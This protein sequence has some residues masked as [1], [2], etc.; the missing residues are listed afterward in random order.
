MVLVADRAGRYVAKDLKVPEGIEL[1]GPLVKRCLA[2]SERPDLLRGHT[3]Y[4]WWP[5]EA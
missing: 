4:R 5:E 3:C 2:L 1:E